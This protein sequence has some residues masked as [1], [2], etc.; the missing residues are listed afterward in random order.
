MLIN[1]LITDFISRSSGLVGLS[2]DL[3]ILADSTSDHILDFIISIHLN[4]NFKVGKNFLSLDQ[5]QLFL[6][7]NSGFH[8]LDQ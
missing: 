3:I 5:T 1:M 2:I 6:L 7:V 4:E 8:E